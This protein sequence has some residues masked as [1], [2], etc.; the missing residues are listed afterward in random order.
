MQRWE[1][2]WKAVGY[3]ET[4]EDALRDAKSYVD[5]AEPTEE[6]LLTKEEE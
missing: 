6:E 2:T 1:F 4:R 3:G 5:T